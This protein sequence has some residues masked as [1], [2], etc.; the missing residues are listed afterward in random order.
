MP[1]ININNFLTPEIK[2]EIISPTEFYTANSPD[3]TPAFFDDSTQLGKDRLHDY[4]DIG[5]L[6]NEQSLI[7]GR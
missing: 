2:Q 3:Q 4:T 7:L 6:F 5:G 1:T